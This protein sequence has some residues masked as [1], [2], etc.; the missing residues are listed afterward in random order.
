MVKFFYTIMQTQ[1]ILCNKFVDFEN[2]HPNRK[3]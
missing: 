1:A 2:N 3:F